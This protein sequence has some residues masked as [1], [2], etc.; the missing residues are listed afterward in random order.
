[1]GYL[2]SLCLYFLICKMGMVTSLL[3]G[4]GELRTCSSWGSRPTRW[5]PPW[6]LF[7]SLLRS[8][9]SANPISS[10][11]KLDSDSD[12]YYHWRP[13]PRPKPPLPLA[14]VIAITS[15][16]VP[17]SEIIVLLQKCKSD[18][19]TPLSGPPK[20]RYLTTSESYKALRE[21]MEIMVFSFLCLLCS[22]L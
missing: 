21:T 18:H 3:G 14:W 15:E 11:F 12:H 1:M 8:N 5:R 9:L 20:A 13:P 4:P 19:H 10:T 6:P 22:S 16:V 17:N 2:T 7:L